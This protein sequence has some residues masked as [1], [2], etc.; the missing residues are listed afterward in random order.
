MERPTTS[1]IISKVRPI[2]IKTN[3]PVEGLISGAYLSAFKGTGIEFS[4]VREYQAGDDPRNIDFKTNISSFE[5]SYRDQQGKNASIK[6]NVT[7]AGEIK[8]I[9]LKE[10]EPPFQCLR[11]Q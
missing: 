6:G 3:S 10:P 4:Q 7:D 9:M 5:Y 1:Q 2:E 11:K 8:D